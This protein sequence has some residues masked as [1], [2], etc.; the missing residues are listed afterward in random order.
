[1]SLLIKNGEVVTPTGRSRCDVLCEGE[2]IVRVGPAL[3]APPAATVVDARGQYVFPGFV[4]AHVHAYLPLKLT[5]SKDTYETVSRAALVGG[6]TCF[7]DFCSPER[8]QDPLAALEIWNSQSVGRAACDYSYHMAVT[9]FDARIESQL[10]E[11]VRRGITSFKVYL[12]YKQS[13]GISDPDLAEVLRLAAELGV[14]VMAHCENAERI[15]QLQEKLIAEGKTGPEWH[16]WSRPPEIEAEGTRHF[17]NMARQAGASAYVVHLSCEEALKQAIEARC[18]GGKVWIET[19]ISFLLL[20]K[21]CA[22][23]PEFEGAKY[24]VSPPLREKGNQAVLWHALADGEINTLSTDHAPFDFNGQKDLGRDNFTLIPNGMPTIEDRIGLLFTYGVM[25]GRISLERMVD[26]ASTQPAKIFGL[27]PK[28]GAILAGGDA[29]LVVYDP[30]PSR[31]I[32]VATQAM[33]VDYNPFEGWMV[34]GRPRIVTVRGEIVVRD[35]EFVGATGKGR[36]IP[37][38]PLRP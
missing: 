24:I 33:N 5:C 23:R 14:V 30:A 26:C 6:T 29:D 18:L 1:M 38:Q 35:G 17:L 34:K 28:K 13:V 9:D 21:S 37:R 4:D 32:S 8:G 15:E 10:R 19:L 16:Y 20:D 2:K 22:E 7:I 3:I 36:F 12:A 31:T 25:Q 11:V 27:Y